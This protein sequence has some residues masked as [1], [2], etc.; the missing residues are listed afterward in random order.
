MWIAK[1]I[2]K[3][4]CLIGNKCEK[5]QVSTISVPFNLYTE[6]GLTFS[7]EFHTLWGRQENIKKFISAVKRDKQ[8]KNVE[9]D[10]N[11]VFLV[12]A[13]KNKLPVTIRSKLQQKLI[14]TKPIHINIKGE[15][16]WEIASWEKKH[17]IDFIEETKKIS[18]YVILESVKKGKIKDIYYTKL[19]PNLT[20]KQKQA[21][22]MAFEEGYY[23]WP[24]RTDFQILSQKMK[25]SV[26]TF[27]EHLKKAE[28]K[29]LPDLIRQL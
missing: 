18:K 26:S 24:K 25:V 9:V 21:M 8:L 6:E 29:I 19:L 28:K 20:D 11:K 23:D 22:T 13:T 15:E 1:V 17:I 10:G 5:Y 27:R 3:H 4:D 7:P 14:W 12:E 2:I 16:H